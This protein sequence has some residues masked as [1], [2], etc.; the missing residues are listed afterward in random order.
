MNKIIIIISV[1]LGLFYSSPIGANSSPPFIIFSVTQHGIEPVAIWSE[2]EFIP[3]PLLSYSKNSQDS[4]KKVKHFAEQLI[5]KNPTLPI[6]KNG[7]HQG[8]F[9]LQKYL[10]QGC[11]D[12]GNL[13]GQLKL[14]DQALKEQTFIGFSTGFPG[15]K[16]YKQAPE[17]I[18]ID[19]IETLLKSIFIEKGLKPNQLQTFHLVRTHQFSP[20]RNIQALSLFATVKRKESKTCHGCSYNLWVIAEKKDGIYEEKF[21]KFQSN[22]ISDDKSYPPSADYQFISSFSTEKVPDKLLVQVNGYEAWHYEIYQRMNGKYKKI[23]T[24][25]GGAC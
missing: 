10:N 11:S 1:V 4:H 15:R 12:F 25:S 18:P 2:K 9:L 8:V 22:E 24:G 13:S 16:F 19:Q 5:K 20:G 6:F 21:V 17:I 14:R 23:F 3:P 7:K